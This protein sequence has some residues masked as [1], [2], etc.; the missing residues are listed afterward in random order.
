MHKHPEYVHKNET[1]CENIWFF[2]KK[3]VTLQIV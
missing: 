1:F 2:A 3:F